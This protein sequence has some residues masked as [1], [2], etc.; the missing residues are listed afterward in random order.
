MTLNA[1]RDNHVAFVVA[2][3]VVLVSVFTLSC[4]HRFE[5]LYLQMN[6][7]LL[8]TSIKILHQIL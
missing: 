4:L 8:T 3:V 2:V 5:C 7:G 1:V 6:H